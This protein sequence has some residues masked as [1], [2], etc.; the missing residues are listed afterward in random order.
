ML[1]KK[2]NVMTVSLLSLCRLQRGES[3]ATSCHQPDKDAQVV[4]V[5]A[6]GW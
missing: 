2:A 4:V 6:L 3:A 1:A 5:W